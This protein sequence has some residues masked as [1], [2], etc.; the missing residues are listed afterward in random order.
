LQIVNDA[1][2]CQAFLRTVKAGAALGIYNTAGKR[3]AGL[4]ADEYGGS[5]RIA[6]RP[7]KRWYRF[8]P[9]NTATGM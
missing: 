8:L 4:I 3:V 1:G 9:T 6:T 5:I 2:K 7:V